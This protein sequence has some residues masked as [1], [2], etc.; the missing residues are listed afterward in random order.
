M[1]ALGAEPVPFGLPSASHV[2]N[3]TALLRFSRATLNHSLR[4]LTVVTGQAGL[5]DR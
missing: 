3:G 1:C 4:T 5:F 2:R